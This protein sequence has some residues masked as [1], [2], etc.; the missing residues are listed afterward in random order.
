MSKRRSPSVAGQP[1][2]RGGRG[3][4]MV[5]MAGS[6]TAAPR[7]RGERRGHR[8]RPGI[9]DVSPAH[10]GVEGSSWGFPFGGAGQPRARGGRGELGQAIEA[11]GL[12]SPAHAGVQAQTCGLR[13]AGPGP[14]AQDAYCT[15]VGLYWPG[16]AGVDRERTSSAR[17]A[18]SRRRLGA[19]P[20]GLREKYVPE[21]NRSSRC[22]S[23][24]PC[25]VGTVARRPP[26]R[27]TWWGCGPGSGS[28]GVFGPGRRWRTA[29]AGPIPVG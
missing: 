29:V 20:S 16:A 6:S 1:R 14:L 8:P 7:T 3:R 28:R 19:D 9:R 18:L 4:G 21:G 22:G 13:C 2:A 23:A 26:C 17:T 25:A 10:A 11:T 15:R 24:D 12:V 5:P 27:P